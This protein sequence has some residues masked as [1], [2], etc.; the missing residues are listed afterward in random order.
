MLNVNF[1]LYFNTRKSVNINA[2]KNAQRTLRTL[3]QLKRVL[4]VLVSSLI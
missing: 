3:F 2:F 4:N 1:S